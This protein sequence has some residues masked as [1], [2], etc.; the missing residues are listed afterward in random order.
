MRTTR[1]LALMT[2]GLLAAGSL[3]ACGGAEP[4]SNDEAKEVLLSEDDFPLDGFKRGEVT[5]GQAKDENLDP[6]Q[7][8]QGLE[9]FG[10][11]SKECEKALD[12]MGDYKPSDHM[13]EGA[14][15][16]YTNS[17]KSVVVA[18]GG[19]KEDGDK[20][21]DSLSLLGKECDDMEVS[22]GGMS[23]KVKFDEIDEDD[24]RGTLITMDAMG[25]KMEVTMGGRL[26]GENFVGVIGN[27]VSKDDVL[28]VADEQAKAIEDK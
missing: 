4:L 5:D 8:K 17:D 3:S 15:V 16:E 20:M 10:E 23:M 13:D 19:V 11:L 18:A 26:V 2:T 14:S 9:Q 6:S 24:Y 21:L 7:M 28:K 12:E 1:V 27:Q 22:E 25:Q